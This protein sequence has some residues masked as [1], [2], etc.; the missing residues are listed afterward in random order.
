MNEKALSVLQ[1]LATSFDHAPVVYEFTN[2]LHRFR[3]E[4]GPTHWLYISRAYIDVRTEQDLLHMLERWRIVE[5][6][7]T[8]QRPRCLLLGERGILEVNPNYGR[9]R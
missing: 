1:R 2:D 6:L 3:I 8:S 9:P 4:W 7:R 5:T